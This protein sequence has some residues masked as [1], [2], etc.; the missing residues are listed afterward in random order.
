VSKQFCRRAELSASFIIPSLV[1]GDAA[2]A[3]GFEPPRPLLTGI[4]LRGICQRVSADQRNRL[5]CLHLSCACWF[6]WKLEHC[7]LLTPNQ[8]SQ[9]RNPTVWKLQRIMMCTPVILVDLP[10]DSCP[11]IEGNIFPAEEPARGYCAAKASS[12]PGRTQTAMFSSSG[13]ANP[14]VPVVK[15]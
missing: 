14:I 2:E 11:V 1:H 7:C 6:G 8:R 5:L 15:L 3:V 9:E 10:E 4:T 12:V 13:A